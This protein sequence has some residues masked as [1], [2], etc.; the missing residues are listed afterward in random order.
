MI[1]TLT[2][3]RRGKDVP[4]KGKVLE[5]KTLI[6]DRHTIAVDLI[7]DKCGGEQQATTYYERTDPRL[8][9]IGLFN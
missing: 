5:I 1:C 8:Q 3:I 7:C 4:C 6:S 2:I 9:T